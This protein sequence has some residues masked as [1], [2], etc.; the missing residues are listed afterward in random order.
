ML[1][2][3]KSVELLVIPFSVMVPAVSP[4]NV[5]VITRFEPLSTPEWVGGFAWVPMHR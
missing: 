3:A 2:L 1:R 5:T 4:L